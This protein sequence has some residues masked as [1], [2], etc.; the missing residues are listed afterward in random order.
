MKFIQIADVHLGVKPDAGK[1]WSE[2][3][4][5][6][7]WNSFAGVIKLAVREKADLL[8]IAGDLFHRQPLKRELKEA[9]ALFE[10]LKSTQVVL[11]AGNHDY[12]HPKS[13]YR[14]FIWPDNVH[15]IKEQDLTPVYLGTLDVTVWG[16]SYWSPEDKRHIYQT[17]KIEGKGLQILLGH[18]GDEKH[19]PFTPAEILEAGYDYAAFGHIHIPRRLKEH[20]IIMSGSL[21]PTDCNDF[22][23]HGYWMG[24]LDKSGCQVQFYPVRNCEYIKTIVEITPKMGQRQILNAVR[25]QLSDREDFQ[26]S[27]VVLTGRRDADIDIPEEEILLLPRVVKV[28]DMTAADYCFEKLKEEYSGTLLAA[29]IEKMDGISDKELKEDA[30]YYGVWA[31]LAAMN[32]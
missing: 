21:E 13:Y 25:Q 23:P 29:F 32:E 8:L 4:A 7:I 18:G 6:D 22:G 3:R 30:L 27:H 9:A 12:M 28:F 10:E 1:S 31:M 20:R 5:E 19:H 24:E 26:I 2:R 15:F 17:G 14:N 11:A 16:A